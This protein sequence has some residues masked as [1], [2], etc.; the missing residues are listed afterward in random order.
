[1][2]DMSLST[3]IDDKEIYNHPLEIVSEILQKHNLPKQTHEHII[4]G[5][6]P[7]LEKN[8]PSPEICDFFSK[9]CRD[10]PRS[11]IVIEMFTPVVQR[12]LKHNGDFGKYPHM[13]LFVQ[14][15]LMALVS[16]NGGMQTVQNFV[17]SMHSLSS[18]CPFPRVLPNFVAVCL[19]AI[20][21]CFEIP[22]KSLR[23]Q[24]T[25][26]DMVSDYQLDKEE[27]MICYT[28]MMHTM[29]KFEDWRTHLAQ[30]LQS[31]PFPDK[32]LTSEKFIK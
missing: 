10:S 30:L 2:I 1:M 16:Q 11:H 5:L 20:H 3:P 26:N 12:I 6:S 18:Q 4:V 23:K 9:H 24:S 28:T 21:G 22:F 31:R 29:S 27:Q 19:A 17:V 32:A 7:L 15:Y 13:R 8:H 25:T 14:N